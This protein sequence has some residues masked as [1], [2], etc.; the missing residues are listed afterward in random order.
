M[1]TVTQALPVRPY[2]HFRRYE[3]TGN[4]DEL[5][6]ALVYVV[7]RQHE[8]V[9]VVLCQVECLPVKRVC[10][11]HLVKQAIIHMFYIEKFT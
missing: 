7:L 4:P 11:T 8:T 6:H 2:L 3:K 10:L 5:Q 1:L 9:K